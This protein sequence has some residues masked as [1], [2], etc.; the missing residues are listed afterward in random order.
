VQLD[1]SYLNRRPELDLLPYCRENQVGVIVRGPLA[2][3]V[4]AGKFNHQTQ[5]HDDVRRAWNQGPERRRFLRRLAVVEKLRWLDRPGR[6]MSQAALQFVLAHPAVSVAIP[7]AK[8]PDQARSNAAAAGM[9]M[10]DLELRRLSRVAGAPS[11]VRLLLG[12]AK[13]LFRGVLPHRT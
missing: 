7:G 5:F 2:M 12:R 9:V 4:A 1:Y 6:S 3:G 8:A 10:P 11:R 13:R